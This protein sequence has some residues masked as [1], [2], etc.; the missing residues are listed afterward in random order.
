MIKLKKGKAYIHKVSDE[1]IVISNIKRGQGLKPTIVHFG[2]ESLAANEFKKT[3]KHANT[4]AP[5]W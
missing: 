5:K 2:D 1:E 3:Y 4:G